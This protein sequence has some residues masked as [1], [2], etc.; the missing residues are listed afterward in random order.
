MRLLVAI[1][2]IAA[3][4]LV[5]IFGEPALSALLSNSPA[6]TRSRATPTPLP[7]GV[8]GVATLSTKPDPA[9]DV[10]VELTEAELNARLAREVVGKPVGQT[11]IGS[12]TF[13]SLTVA[14]KSG[15]AEIEGRAR[16]GGASVPVEASAGFTPDGT[17][18]VRVTLAEAK[19]AGL[20]IPAN[21]RGEVEKQIQA[22]MD[23]AL[24]EQPLSVRAVEIGNGRLRA[25]GQARR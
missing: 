11:A 1:L 19:V 16:V 7:P 22:E 9:R 25:I 23:R 12:A 8:K 24:A 20:P 4:A 5:L 21:A 15:R 14:L 10:V 13:D 18:G 2:L 6:I 17:G 3:V